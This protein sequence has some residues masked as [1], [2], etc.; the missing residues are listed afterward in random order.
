MDVQSDIE[1]VAS[2]HDLAEFVATLRQAFLQGH[3]WEN[4]DLSTSLEAMSA[5]IS[6]MDGYYENNGERCPDMPTWRTFAQILA[7][8]TVY[9]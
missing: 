8:A 5:W 2:R 9:E 1:K 3:G 7:A 6:D 4:R